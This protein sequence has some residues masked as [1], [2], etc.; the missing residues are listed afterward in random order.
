MVVGGVRSSNVVLVEAY[1]VLVLVTRP[2][3]DM[4]S[5]PLYLLLQ[6]L[7]FLGVLDILRMRLLD[8]YSR[9]C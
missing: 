6:L 1:L 7:N 4:V 2:V 8:H 9:W 3:L 5:L